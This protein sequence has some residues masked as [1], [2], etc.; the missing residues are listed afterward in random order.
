MKR[1]IALLPLG[2]ILA[3]AACENRNAVPLGKDFGN[4]TQHNMSVHIINPDPVTEGYGAPALD[5]IRA[6]G[7]MDRYH[8]REVS[9]PETG[10][11]S[12][13]D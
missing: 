2:L 1:A 8:E 6:K 11:V 13:A 12:G 4:A 9:A 5:G 3:V 10:G 7:A